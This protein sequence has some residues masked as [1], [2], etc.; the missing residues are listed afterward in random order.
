MTVWAS[1]SRRIGLPTIPGSPPNRRSHRPWLIKATRAGLPRFE[2]DQSDAQGRAQNHGQTKCREGA[3]ER[4]GEIGQQRPGADQRPEF[5]ADIQRRGEK[6]VG[7]KHGSALP[8]DEQE[9]QG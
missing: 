8:E 7:D 3:P 5:C 9:W 6:A 1:P 2:I 4:L